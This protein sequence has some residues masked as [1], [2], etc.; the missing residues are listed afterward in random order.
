MI[1]ADLDLQWTHMVAT[2][3]LIKFA[4]IDVD[5]IFV[6]NSLIWL[7]GEV[8][9]RFDRHANAP[10]G[11]G[12]CSKRATRPGGAAWGWRSC[13]TGSRGLRVGTRCGLAIAPREPIG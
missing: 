9:G 7:D 8:P 5:E 13:G 11:R 12:T 2:T 10:R 3:P 6:P 1:I 4:R